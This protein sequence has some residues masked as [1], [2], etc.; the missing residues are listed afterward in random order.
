MNITGMMGHLNIIPC[1]GGEICFPRLYLV[2][3]LFWWCSWFLRNHKVA[4]FDVVFISAN[5]ILKMKCP[6][7]T[8]ENKNSYLLFKS[9][10]KHFVL[11]IVVLVHPLYSK[12]L[13]C[14]HHSLL[15]PLRPSGFDASFPQ[16]APT[17]FLS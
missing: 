10:T 6:N 14:L 4:W 8:K 5:V 2:A 12:I 13:K 9:K 1:G 11:Q 15:I 16:K 3:L 7:N 17:L